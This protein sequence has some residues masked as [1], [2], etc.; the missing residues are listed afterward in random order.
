MGILDQLKGLL[1]KGEEL[2]KEHPDQVKAALD[3]AEAVVDDKT[4]HKYD[5]QI[6]DGA[7]KV[8]GYLTDDQPKA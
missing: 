8:A 3:K 2:A 7:S 4:G 1:G 5:S 6:H